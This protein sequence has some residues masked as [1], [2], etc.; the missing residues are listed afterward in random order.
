MKRDH[1]Q[2]KKSFRSNLE[3]SRKFFFYP[4]RR[5]A[6]KKTDMTPFPQYEL[7]NQIDHDDDIQVGGLHYILCSIIEK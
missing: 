1:M 6:L 2:K 7:I 4:I 3:D 5:E